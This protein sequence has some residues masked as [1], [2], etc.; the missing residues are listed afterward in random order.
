MSSC[1]QQKKNSRNGGQSVDAD[2]ADS[3]HRYLIL[4]N[5][6]KYL[7]HLKIRQWVIFYSK[8][9]HRSIKR[10][11]G[12]FIS[13]SLYIWTLNGEFF[14]ALV[15]V[16]LF[17]VQIECQLVIDI[18]RKSHRAYKCSFQSCFVYTWCHESEPF[19]R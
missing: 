7:V 1:V 15:C 14:V 6:W 19:L 16:Y 5:H 2:L 13:N 17:A 11:E 8:R 3:Y 4:Q 12:N 9:M 18:L 10:S